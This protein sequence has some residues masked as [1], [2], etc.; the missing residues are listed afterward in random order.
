VIDEDPSRPASRDSRRGECRSRTFASKS[1]SQTDFLLCFSFFLL[2]DLQ[3]PPP[4]P[5]VMAPVPGVP[6]PDLPP[7]SGSSSVPRHHLPSIGDLSAFSLASSSTSSNSSHFTIPPPHPNRPPHPLT[8]WQVPPPHI[9]AAPPLESP[10]STPRSQPS[11]TGFPPPSNGSGPLPAFAFRPS[12]EESAAINSG[13]RSDM[14]Y[15]NHSFSS[16][17]PNPYDAGATYSGSHSFPQP[18]VYHQPAAV[19]VPGRDREWSQG[20]GGSFPPIAMANEVHEARPT[21][22]R[23]DTSSSDGSTSMRHARTPTSPPISRIGSSMVREMPSQPRHENDRRDQ[24]SEACSSDGRGTGSAGN[25]S[26]GYYQGAYS[27]DGRDN[28]PPAPNHYFSGSGRDHPAYGPRRPSSPESHWRSNYVSGSNSLPYSS[29]LGGGI[30][31]PGL[32]LHRHNSHASSCPHHATYINHPPPPPPPP[33]STATDQ[34]PTVLPPLSQSSTSSSTPSTGSNSFPA[35]DSTSSQAQQH[36]QHLSQPSALRHDPTFPYP[37]PQPSSHSYHHNTAS[38]MA[39]RPKKTHLSTRGGLDA[40]GYSHRPNLARDDGALPGSVRPEYPFPYP[41]RQSFSFL[42]LFLSLV[43]LFSS[44]THLSGF[45]H[46]RTSASVLSSRGRNRRNDGESSRWRDLEGTSQSR[47]WS[48]RESGI[49]GSRGSGD[50]GGGIRCEF[51]D[52][53]GSTSRE[54]SFRSDASPFLSSFWLFFPSLL[55]S[56]R[57]AHICTS[58]DSFSHS[59]PCAPTFCSHDLTSSFLF[60]ALVLPSALFF[61]QLQRLLFCSLLSCSNFRALAYST[62]IPRIASATIL[63]HIYGRYFTFNRSFF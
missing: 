46:H 61:A 3:L 17:Y 37:H 59:L 62:H 44:L 34:V 33:S 19:Y 39:S 18:G 23:R 16:S 27:S 32:P 21:H 49:A 40:H 43:Y 36:Q 9:V 51:R 4:I 26:A 12:P 60:P 14:Q 11:H 38:L 22:R 25:G 42:L 7:Y 41:S 58:Y 53:V 55:P 35:G 8:P 54:S 6:F 1:F 45:L 30:H 47:R 29:S 20:G 15:S 13:S 10:L 5:S 24:P 63:A 56:P 48:L 52:A 31:S 2:Q 28:Y 57:L 50:G